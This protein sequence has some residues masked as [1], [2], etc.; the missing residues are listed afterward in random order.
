VAPL[1][2]WLVTASLA[3]L[4]RGN[5]FQPK[6]IKK[7]KEGHFILI[8]GRI[9]QDELSILNICAPNARTATFIKKNFSKAQSTHCTSHNNS[10]RFQH[11]TLTNGQILETET[12][13]RHMDTNRTFYPKTKG[14]TFSVAHGTSSKTDHIISQKQASTDTKIL[15]LSH[16]S[17]Q[18]TTD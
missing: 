3:R 2:W 11:P 8:K 16:A 17:Y 14:Y 15:K 18:F 7:D 5:N 4:E 1:K 13:Q 9:Y 10:G 12:K 6:V